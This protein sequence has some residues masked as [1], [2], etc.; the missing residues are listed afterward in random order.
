LARQRSRLTASLERLRGRAEWGVKAYAV[1]G[2]GPRRGARQS[3]RRAP[4]HFRRKLAD[5]NAVAIAQQALDTM[6]EALHARLRER[7]R[8]RG[9]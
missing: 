9:A 7:R 2:D 5:R 6:V 8:R 4:T 3:R 1:D